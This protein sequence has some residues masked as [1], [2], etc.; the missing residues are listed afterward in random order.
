MTTV[1]LAFSF[2]GFLKGLLMFVFILSALLLALV[3]LLQEPK[4]GGLSSAFGGVGAETFGVQSG[5]VSKFTAYVAVAFILSALLYAA[6]REEG[7]DL[8]PSDRTRDEQSAPEEPGDA[9]E[10]STPAEDR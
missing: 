7:S 5:G 6:V 9:D 8:A 1:L 2:T 4:G 10:E 3:I